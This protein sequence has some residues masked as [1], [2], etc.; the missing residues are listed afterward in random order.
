MSH[1]SARRASVY[2]LRMRAR[3]VDEAPQARVTAIYT[4]MAR[5]LRAHPMLM[6]SCC[7]Y[8]TRVRT[9]ARKDERS[10]TVRY[11]HVAA[12]RRYRKP[13]R[14]SAR[15]YKRCSLNMSAFSVVGDNEDA[16]A[17]E[18]AKHARRGDSAKSA[19][20]RRA[21]VAAC[22]TDYIRRDAAARR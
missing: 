14:E 2:T 15:C 7:R 5:R 1:A 8:A 10:A 3:C 21:A 9:R 13:R 22:L 6:P 4:L 20:R 19:A 18:D 11:S 16:R 17:V 12:T